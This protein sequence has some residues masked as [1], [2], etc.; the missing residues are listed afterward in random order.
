MDRLETHVSPASPEFRDNHSR[1]SALVDELRDR[2]LDRPSG[3]RSTVPRTP[4]GPGQAPGPRAPRAAARSGLAL[5]R[6]LGA[7]GVGRLRRRRARRRPGHGHRPRLRPRGARRRQRRHGQGRHL[8][9][10]H[11]EEAPARAAGRAREPPAVPLPRRLRRRV[12]AAPGGGLSRSRALR[13]DLLQ[14]GPHVRRRD[15]PGRRRDGI[16][17]RGRR[18]RARDVGRDDHRQGHRARSSSAVRRS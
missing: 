2:R 5:S 6:A 1:M 4:P 18:L 14:P 12:P 15:S 8:L 17:H 7:R 3:R 13:A 16:L 9:S 11:R 10:A